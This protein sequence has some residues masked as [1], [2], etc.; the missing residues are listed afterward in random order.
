MLVATIASIKAELGRR[1]IAA[2]SKAEA[3]RHVAKQIL[4]AAGDLE[5]VGVWRA[6]MLGGDMQLQLDEIDVGRRSQRIA[7]AHAQAQ[8]VFVALVAAQH[9]VAAFDRTPQRH[10]RRHIMLC[11]TMFSKFLI[12]RGGGGG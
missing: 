2:R 12:W 6:P 8:N 1:S 3:T 10:C 11:N 7:L 5:A 4:L 9:H